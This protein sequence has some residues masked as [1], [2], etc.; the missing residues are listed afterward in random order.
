MSF[1]IN[2]LSNV[3]LSHI[4]E[5]FVTDSDGIRYNVYIRS[6]S[7]KVSTKLLSEDLVL[8][9]KEVIKQAFDSNQSQIPTLDGL[10]IG[11]SRISIKDKEIKQLAEGESINQRIKSIYER[12][13]HLDGSQPKEPKV[14]KKPEIILEEVKQEEEAKPAPKEEKPLK[15]HVISTT[16]QNREG[17]VIGEE[18]VI[19]ENT[20]GVFA[21]GNRDHLNRLKEKIH[22][23]KDPDRL[24]DLKNQL[25]RAEAY[26]KS[27]D[28]FEKENLTWV[29]RESYHKNIHVKDSMPPLTINLRKVEMNG[30]SFTRSGALSDF[31]N[32][33]TNLEDLDQI[34]KELESCDDEGLINFFKKNENRISRATIGNA[35]SKGERDP[36]LKEYK[37]KPQEVKNSLLTTL[38]KEK[39]DREYFVSNLL[40]QDMY[41]H[42]RGKN[43]SEING[44]LN[45]I[46]LGLLNQKG[47]EE[48]KE[49]FVRNEFN[50]IKDMH[51]IYKAFHGREIIFDGKGPFLDEDGKIHMPF[52][53]HDPVKLNAA[54]LNVSI[55]AGRDNKGY[56]KEINHE[57]FSVLVKALK[58]KVDAEKVKALEA[59]LNSSSKSEKLEVALEI[60]DFLMSQDVQLSVNCY[61]G[62]DRT[63]VLSALIVRS[64]LK[65]SLK[66]DPEWLEQVSKD[67]FDPEKGT[68]LKVLSDITGKTGLKIN[69][70]KTPVQKL[71]NIRKGIKGD[72][73]RL[74]VE[75]RF[76]KQIGWDA[77]FGKSEKGEG[78]V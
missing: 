44:T 75:A 36:I 1:N 52:E 45:F 78:R 39:K 35:A 77:W 10:T 53:G 29:S 71:I 18:S 41:T 8:E 50:Q 70:N 12:H 5:G 22:F 9:V 38:H 64:L 42:L 61:S 28:N 15:G 13:M 26:E 34:I 48:E 55:S 74:G 21:K 2:N 37:N 14:S 33:A 59:R 4:A 19:R 24:M 67:M 11:N 6:N 46:R 3:D 43:L 47:S 58:G 60:S 54:Y 16:Y 62:K 51:Y 68:A 69:P 23:E 72:I 56:Q 31:R 32:G 73:Q 57:A 65:E 17:T 30:K 63:G 27:V 49:G 76:W 66:D 40:L 20:V 7:N 25:Q